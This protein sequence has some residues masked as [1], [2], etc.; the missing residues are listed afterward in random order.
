MYFVVHQSA[1]LRLPDSGSRMDSSLFR[2]MARIQDEHWWF[3][4]RRKILKRLIGTLDLSQPARIL[5]LGCGT[6]GNLAMLQHFGKVCAVEMDP[7]ARDYASQISGMNVEAGHLPDGLPQWSDRFDLVCLFD[8]LEHVENDV[9]ALLRIRELLTSGGKALITV[10]AY[11]WLFGSHDRAHHHFRRYTKT[12]LTHKAS[13]SGFSVVR[14]GYFN[15]LLFPAVVLERF[16]SQVFGKNAADTIG[17]PPAWFNTMLYRI[18]ATEAMV[19]P[20]LLF[21]FGTSIVAVIKAV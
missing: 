5:E 13:A 7:F 21:P 15:T 17:V 11:R 8:V 12:E 9:Q 6:G 1:S 3:R 19:A 20:Y 4:A 16:T 2:E 10:P 14:A 18:F